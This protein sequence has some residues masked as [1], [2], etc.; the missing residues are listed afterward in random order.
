GLF[1]YTKPMPENYTLKLKWRCWQEDAN[2]GVFIRFP[3]PTSADY[4]SY[5]NRAYVAVNFGFEVQIDDIGMPDGDDKHRTGAIYNQQPS[6]MLASNPVG[7][8]NDYEIIVEGQQYTVILNGKQ[9]T[10]FQNSDATRGI[11]TRSFVGLQS[12][13]GFV[14]FRDIQ[15]KEVATTRK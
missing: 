15:F 9:V 3:E 4:N 6:S 13:T 11:P 8:W 2:S 1:W 10:T 12:H 14:A 7:Q 5:D